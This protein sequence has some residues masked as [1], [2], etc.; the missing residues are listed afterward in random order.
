MSQTT[1]TPTAVVT[2]PVVPLLK[3]GHLGRLLRTARDAGDLLR[4]R[5]PGR[6]LAARRQRRPRVGA[7]RAP[8][9]RLPLPLSRGRDRVEG[10]V[11]PQPGRLPAARPRRRPGGRPDRLRGGLRLR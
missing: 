4:Q 5:R 8:P 9:A 3:S 11:C 7:R 1:A 10:R 2:V 6:A